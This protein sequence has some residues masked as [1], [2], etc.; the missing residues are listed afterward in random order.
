VLLLLLFCHAYLANTQL[1]LLPLH[2]LLTY[3]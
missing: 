2:V 3:T 1:P